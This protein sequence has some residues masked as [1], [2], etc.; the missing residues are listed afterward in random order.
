M[1]TYAN[2]IGLVGVALVVLAYGLFAAG[3]L[4]SKDWRYP[5]L[6]MVGT[7]GIL[8]SLLY[9][10]NLPSV[11]MQVLWILFSLVGLGRILWRKHRG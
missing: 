1:E 10:W 7:A 4:D 9:A 5:V 2:E 3:K 11:V 6:N 8:F